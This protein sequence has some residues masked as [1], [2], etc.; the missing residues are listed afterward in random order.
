MQ[1]RPRPPPPKRYETMPVTHTRKEPDTPHSTLTFAAV[2][3]PREGISTFRGRMRLD[4][5]AKQFSSSP[6]KAVPI[7]NLVCAHP[8]LLQNLFMF[9]QSHLNNPLIVDQL[10]DEHLD[11]EPHLVCIVSK[12]LFT[13]SLGFAAFEVLNHHYIDFG[14]YQRRV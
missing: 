6:S 7:L 12:L 13:V 10:T 3:D 4:D 11:C 9:L 14:L 2:W 8:S 1:P 5:S